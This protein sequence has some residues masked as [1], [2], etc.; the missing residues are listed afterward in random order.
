[1]NSKHESVNLDLLRSMAVLFVVGFHIYL[2]FL[3]NHDLGR[4][5]FARM[6]FSYI[7]QWGVLIFFVHTSLVLMFSLER[8]QLRSPG[9]PLFLPFLTRRVF[10]I[11]PLAVFSVLFVWLLRLPVGTMTDGRFGYL[12]LRWHGLLSN[13]LLIQNVFRVKSILP[14]LWTLPFEMQMYLF[15]AVIY[16]FVSRARG[17]AP[18]IALWGAAAFMCTHTRHLREWGL[19]PLVALAEYVPCFLAG[20]VAF[21]LTKWRTLRLP[22]ALWPITLAIITFVYLRWVQRDYL[23]CF[24]LGLAVPQF[25]E[26][27]NPWLRKISQIVARYSYGIYLTHF[28]CIWLAF[29]GLGDLP[30]WGRWV[31]LACTVAIAPVVLYHGLEQPMIRLGGKI[32]A[33]LY[34]R[35]M[36][37]RPLLQEMAP[38]TDIG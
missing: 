15:L 37:K 8:Q 6:D 35:P 19:G 26:I 34:A 23:C 11:Y 32:A 12:H 33:G 9:K 31:V 21:R 1:M 25:R 7:G 20:I 36:V 29:Q 22:A 10:R 16:I 17:V 28:I 30:M 4:I 13:F 14:T 5:K 3:K 2:Y 18:I 24:L 38:C 27:A